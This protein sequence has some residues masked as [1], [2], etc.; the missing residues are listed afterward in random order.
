MISPE[1]LTANVLASHEEVPDPRLRVIIRS[2]ITH[3]H[4]FATEVVLTQDEWAAGIAFLTAVGH[5][6]DDRRNEFILLS[7][8][9]GLSM[10]VD[11]VD[12]YSDAGETESTVLGPFWVADAPWRENGAVIARPE[13]GDPLHLTG[14]VLT[15][16]GEP[17][18]EAIVD[19]WQ[20]S[21][22]GLYDVQDPEQTPGNLRGR[23]RTGADGGFDCWTV[24]PVPY[25]V[26]TDGPVG[27]MVAALGRHPWRAA[28][29]H[30]RVS[31]DGYQA[32]TTHLFDA[33]SEYLDSDVVFGVKEMLIRSIRRV[34]GVVPE[35]LA[36]KRF[37]YFEMSGDFIL[38]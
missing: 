23:F 21:A 32:L 29:I 8:T 17:I 19:V 30:F 25:P 20:A 9:L 27:K 37:E 38:A 13:D 28:H 26:P 11:L 5:M 33:E 36:S 2:L 18:A 22:K 7:D 3:L 15:T 31:A 35:E 24:R 34:E 10:L 16:G 1:E 14:R 12:H 4:A 6:T